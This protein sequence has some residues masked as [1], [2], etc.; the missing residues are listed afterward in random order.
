MTEINVL[1]MEVPEENVT[2]SFL[3]WEHWMATKD[4]SRIIQA[5]STS[6]PT[7]LAI[8][9]N[10]AVI[11]TVFLTESLRKKVRITLF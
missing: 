10:M 4:E 1:G 2:E 9:P 5:V 11:T 6:V 3:C 8:F 7:L